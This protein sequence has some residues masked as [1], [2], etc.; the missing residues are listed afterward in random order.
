MSNNIHL[1]ELST[2]EAPVITESKRNDWVEYGE[3]NNYY[4]H[5]IDMYTNSTTN[6]AIINNITRLVYGKGLNATDAQVKPNDYAQMM[7]LFGKKD[8]RQLVTDLKLLGQCAMQVIYSKDRKKIVN[9]H[10]IPVQLLRPEKC[11]EDGIIESYYYSDNW[12]EVRKYPPKRISAFGC[13]KDGLEI[14]MVKPY[15]V[16]MKYFALVDYTGGLPYCA[17]EE[18]ISTYLRNEVSTGFSGR[19]V[20]NFSNGIPSE[21]QMHEIKAKVLNQLSGP[22]GDKVIV[23]FNNNAESKTT[24]DAMPVNDAPDLYSTLSE[25][26][27]RKIMLAHNVTSPLLFGIAS[28]NGFSSNSDELKD[29]FALFSNMVIKPMQEL[30]IDA[31][32]EILAYNGISL[33][34]YFKTLKPLEFIEIGVQVGTEELE[35]ETGVELSADAEGAELIALGEEA[36]PEWLLLDQYEVDYDIDEEENEMLN[37]AVKLNMTDKLVNLVST[38]SAFPNAKSGQDRVIDGIK[39]ITRYVYEG[40]RKADSRPFCRNMMK[41]DKIYRKEDIIRM[42]SQEVNKGW[43]PRGRN[44][45]SIWKW[46]GGGNCYHRWNKQIYVSFEGTGI[47]V[48]SPKASRIAVKKAEKY[49]YKIRNSKLVS[50]RP[51]DMPNQGFLPSNK[52]Q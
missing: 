26:C 31:F 18:D 30:L 40:E 11:N 13:S 19:S 25:E 21:S 38:G 22:T 44:T 2:Y 7:A 16:G 9:V 8:V 17:L 48:R 24:V 39:F 52:R 5:L 45:Y 23:S 12:Q 3:D 42:G 15:S 50:Q 43:G 33:N 47:D 1:L 49:G 20:I 28:S 46:K 32:D 4:Q 35:E 10:H 51:I 29:S 34:L 37:K 27:L 41:A 6:N 36:H 14:L